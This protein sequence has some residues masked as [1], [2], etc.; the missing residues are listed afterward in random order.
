MPSGPNVPFQ[1]PPHDH[2]DKGRM[3][4]PALLLTAHK[5]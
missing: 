2:D 5:G 4:M 3:K 1:L